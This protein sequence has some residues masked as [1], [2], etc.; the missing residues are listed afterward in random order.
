MHDS[1]F[2]EPFW[3]DLLEKSD[4]AFEKDPDR[5]RA[6]LSKRDFTG[7]SRLLSLSAD[8]FAVCD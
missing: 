6:I 7:I 3:T 1:N 4:P 2:E 8:L 5:N